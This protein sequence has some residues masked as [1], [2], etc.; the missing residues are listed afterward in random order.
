[1]TLKNVEFSFTVTRVNE[2]LSEFFIPYD[3]NTTFVKKIFSNFPE[4]L[5]LNKMFIF[6]SDEILFFTKKCLLSTLKKKK[7]TFV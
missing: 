2:L 4:F 3:K 7:K 1:M 6:I 5:L